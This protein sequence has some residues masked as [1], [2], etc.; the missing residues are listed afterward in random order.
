[1]TLNNYTDDDIAAVHL[2]YDMDDNCTYLI[3]GFELGTR[4]KTPHMQ[5]YIH[6]TEKVSFKQM[7]ER[8]P[9]AHIEAQKSSKEV[10]AYCYCMKDGDFKEYGERPRQ[11]NRTDLEVIKHDIL[12]G[13]T[14]DS[15]ATPYFAQWCQYR[16]AFEAYEELV[17][18][19]YETEIQIW[20]TRELE[21]L[22]LMFLDYDPKRDYIATG[23]E[24]ALEIM[25]KFYSKKYR[26]I[27]L[28]EFNTP[29]VVKDYLYGK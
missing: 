8:L 12:R 25:Q 18:P 21:D 23:M 20:D 19:K 13:A 17:R 6:Y 1:M 22:R 27:M 10:N 24:T 26:K 29:Q 5:I 2:M 16:R 7:L 4:K 28:D 15:I 14:A 11:G 9:G 3:V